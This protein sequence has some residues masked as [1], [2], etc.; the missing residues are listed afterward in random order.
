MRDRAAVLAAVPVY[1][2]GVLVSKEPKKLYTG[3][4]LYLKT[5]TPAPNSSLW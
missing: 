1:S 3:A 2:S 5:C 4:S